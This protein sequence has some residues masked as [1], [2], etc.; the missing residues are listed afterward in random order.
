MDYNQKLIRALKHPIKEI[1]RTTVFIIGEKKLKEALEALERLANEEED[2]M[3][4]IEIAKA[5]VKIN[6]EKSD[7]ILKKMRYHRFPIIARYSQEI[8]H[9]QN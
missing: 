9:S 8:Q 7:Q 2:P 6:S 3:I 5:L 1:R 4:L